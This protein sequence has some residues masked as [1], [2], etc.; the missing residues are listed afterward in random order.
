M[1][2][3]RNEFK[4]YHHSEDYLGG[5]KNLPQGTKMAWAGGAE[6]KRIF[7]SFPYDIDGFLFDLN[8]FFFFFNLTIFPLDI[9]DSD[10]EEEDLASRLENIDLNNAEEVWLSLTHAERAEFE[11]LVASGE[12]DKILPV[13]IPWWTRIP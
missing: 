2:M 4:E 5:Y 13:W 3:N 1:R 12:V 11:S 10:D 6:P 7:T 8:H 9:P